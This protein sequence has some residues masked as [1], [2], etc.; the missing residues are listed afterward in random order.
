MFWNNDW[1]VM[2]CELMTKFDELIIREILLKKMMGNVF[3]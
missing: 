2:V 1:F 3:M